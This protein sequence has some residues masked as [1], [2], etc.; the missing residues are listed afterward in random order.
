MTKGSRKTTDPD[1][2]VDGFPEKNRMERISDM[3]D[4]QPQSKCSRSAAWRIDRAFTEVAQQWPDRTAIEIGGTSISYR[5]LEEKSNRLA[6]RL[7]GSGINPG[8]IVAVAANDIASFAI[9]ALATLKVGAAY[10]PIDLRYS[11][12]RA[13]DV[14][15]E[16]AARLI[17]AEPGLP[18]DLIPAALPV[19][20]SYSDPEGLEPFPST[21]PRVAT[22]PDDPAYLCY[23]SG[24]T[25][26]PKGVVIGHA[27]I[28]GLLF[29][30]EFLPYQSH[31]RVGQTTTFAFDVATLEVWG[32]L[33]QGACLINIPKEIISSPRFLIT[34]LEREKISSVWLTTSHFN[35]VVTRDPAAFQNID[36]VMIGGEAADPEVI[37]RVFA[38]GRVPRR[39]INGYGPTEATA[40]AT[41]HDIGKDD[42]EAGLIPIG[43][44]LRDRTVCIRDAALQPVPVGQEGELLIGGPAI[45]H[46]YLGDAALTDDKF[47]IDPTGSGQR[48]YRTGDLCRELPD[49][50]FAYVGRIDEQVKIR[51]FRVELG[52]VAAAL[53]KLPDVEEAVVLAREKSFGTKELIG[54]VRSR[55]PVSGDA[56]RGLLART[57]QDFMLP[58]QIYVVDTFPLKPSGKLDR[59]ALLDT[60]LLDIAGTRG[61]ALADADRPTTETEAQLVGIWQE[62]LRR[63]DIGITQ[64]FQ[65]LG[66]DSLAMMELVLEIESLLDQ[67]LS[68]QDLPPVVTIA[69]LAA[70]IDGRTSGAGAKE[71]APA[72]AFLISIPW[73]MDMFPAAFGEALGQGQPSRQLQV[74]PSL[75]AAGMDRGDVI[76]RI[77]GE[78]EAQILALSP[79]GPYAIA[80]YSFSGLVAY[81]LARRLRAQ[82]HEVK[83]LVLIDSYFGKELVSEKV[84]DFLG[85]PW[86]EKLSK[87]KHR[88][89]DTISGAPEVDITA[90]TGKGPVAALCRQAMQTYKPRAYDGHTLI[91]RCSNPTLTRMRKWTGFLGGPVTDHCIPGDHLSLIKSPDTVRKVADHIASEMAGLS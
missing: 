83:L 16:G 82:G 19:I 56:L 58:A 7:I 72:R 53:A 85:L 88:F 50:R 23:T 43:K 45:A 42:A 4:M 47:I 76:E 57:V 31:D 10:L 61:H 90:R 52:G 20:W 87:V 68:P 80:G 28:E 69:A 18:H 64:E 22:G 27:G 66:G 65:F 38:H 54:F 34:F 89:K 11:H 35:A 84:K 3:N 71:L 8:D 60:A 81:D 2:N 32:T 48:L 79:Q 9:G 1:E 67:S 21:A 33:L 40:L 49:G 36:T 55:K 41:W 62:I 37:A 29:D 25:G 24:S 86:R 12:S 78:L 15:D 91:L 26:K 30:P 73:S 46:G 51:G 13:K 17:L 5:M 39:L 14:L 75:F 44:P 59:T 77:A 74:S 63:Q 70:L 6:H